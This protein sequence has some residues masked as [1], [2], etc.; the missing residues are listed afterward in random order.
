M[1]LVT[2]APNP[3]FTSALKYIILKHTGATPFTPCLLLAPER[4]QYGHST[5]LHHLCHNL[6]DQPQAQVTPRPQGSGRGQ[7]WTVKVPP[8]RVQAGTLAA[9]TNGVPH[10]AATPFM[11]VVVAVLLGIES[12]CRSL[13][14]NGIFLHSSLDPDAAPRAHPPQVC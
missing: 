5:V 6:L 12:V 3:S 14:R 2:L 9:R 11:N 7:Q 8:K 1:S 4:S 13:D 10:N